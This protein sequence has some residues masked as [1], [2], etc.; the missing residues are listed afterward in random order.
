[1]VTNKHN[2]LLYW[3]HMT[4]PPARRCGRC[5]K[6]LII[7]S[8]TED[9]VGFSMVRTKQYICSD[10]ECQSLAD[11]DMAK[12]KEKSVQRE[13]KKQESKQRAIANRTK[14]PKKEEA[15]AKADK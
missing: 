15:E 11:I 1:M 14:K 7:I 3:A 9:M 5:D 4:T 8:T 2:N 10:P 6:E 12:D 13:Q